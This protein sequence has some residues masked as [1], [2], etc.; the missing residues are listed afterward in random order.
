MSIPGWEISRINHA[1]MKRYIIKTLSPFGFDITD[2]FRDI[3]AL[4]N[5]GV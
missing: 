5:L 2:A 4:G 1:G 3:R